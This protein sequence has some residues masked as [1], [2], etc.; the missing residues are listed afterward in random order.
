M[1][2]LLPCRALSRL[3]ASDIISRWHADSR[4]TTALEFGFIAAPFFVLMLAI[5]TVGLHFF[6]IHSLENGVATAARKIRTGEAQLA[7]KTFADF[8]QMVCDESGSYIKCDSHLVIHV[9]SGATFADLDPPTSCATNGTLTPAAA[10]GSNPLT[11]YSGTQGAT[12]LVTACYQW[13]QGKLLWQGMWNLLTVG[14]WSTTH[15][16]KSQA[17]TIIQSTSTFRTE[18]YK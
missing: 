15:T 18:P 6:T 13:D 7:G 8:R 1:R 3:R 16:P 2:A 12:V 5:M 4:G 11:N 17:N 14:G 9:K 10:T